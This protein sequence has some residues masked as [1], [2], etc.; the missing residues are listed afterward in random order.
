MPGRQ[1]LT[2]EEW[3]DTGMCSDVE[4]QTIICAASP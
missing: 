2:D 1:N 4:I 3:V